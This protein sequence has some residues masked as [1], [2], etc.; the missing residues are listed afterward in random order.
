[1]NKLAKV[2]AL[3]L[4]VCALSSTAI[5]GTIS[6]NNQ[7]I[8]TSVTPIVDKGRTYVPLR[9]IAEGMGAKVG[10]NKSN[11]CIGIDKGDTSVSLILGA[12]DAIVNGNKVILNTPAMLKNN[13][14]YVPIRFVAEAFGCSVDYKNGNVYICEAGVTPEIPETTNSQEELSTVYWVAGG[15]S[16]HSTPDC[17]TLGRSKNIKSG[18]IAESHKDDPCNICIHNN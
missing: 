11:G 8:K 9:V 10:F 7:P 17:P 4:S 5:A 14:T 16:Y 18:T 6:I 13:V 3:T 2:L 15:K 1:M 12:C